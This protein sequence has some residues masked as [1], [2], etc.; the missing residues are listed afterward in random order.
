M[1][2]PDSPASHP[3]P[4]GPAQAPLRPIRFVHRGVVQSVQGLPSTLSVLAWL[5]ELW[6]TRRGRVSVQVLN[7]FYL[8]ATRHVSPRLRAFIGWVDE[9]MAALP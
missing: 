2:P 3:A 6:A 7:D 5:R 4:P 9:L 8:L 1:S